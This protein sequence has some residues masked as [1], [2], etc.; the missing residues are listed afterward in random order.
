MSRGAKV[1]SPGVS[2]S[3][4]TDGACNVLDL[5]VMW[6]GGRMERKKKSQLEPL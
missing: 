2:E 3:L 1:W 5:K 6:S 4:G